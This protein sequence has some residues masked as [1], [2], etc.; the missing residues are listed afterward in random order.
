MSEELLEKQE[1]AEEA[2]EQ[3]N[4]VVPETEEENSEEKGKRSLWIVVPIIVAVVV[5]VGA[6]AV[7]GLR[8]MGVINPYE[9][10][11]IDVT[12]RTAADI[13]KEKNYKYEKF[14][15]EYG[16]PDDM[17]KSTSERAVF[18]NIPVKKYVE[19]TPGIESFEQLKAD[20]GWDDTITEDTTMGEALDVTKLSYYVGE[21]QLERFKALYGLS[22]EVTGDTL[23]GEVRNIV[24]TKE[25]E[26][27]QAELAQAQA[28]AEA[29]AQATATAMP[30]ATPVVAQ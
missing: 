4:V 14:L 16:L 9:K 17:P 28:E 12:G 7:M 22:D 29:Q 6:L 11:Y 3:E 18:Y 1:T 8:A 20:M 21:E 15:K 19:K 13:A 10:D 24:D 26:F 27:Y 5:A 30:T 25:Q 2:V 23:Y